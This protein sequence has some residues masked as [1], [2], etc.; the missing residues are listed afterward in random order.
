MA[1]HRLIIIPGYGDRTGYIHRLT[2]SWLRR[3]GVEVE[4]VTFGWRGDSRSYDQKWQ[5]FIAH[6]DRSNPAVVLGISAGASV[7]LRALTEEPQKVLGVVSICGPWTGRYFHADV[8]HTQYPTL[9]S[10]LAPLRPTKFPVNRI[11]TFRPLYDETATTKA[12]SIEGA[13]NV[14][15]PFAFHAVSI[16]LALV[17]YGQT[18]SKFVK[19]PYNVPKAGDS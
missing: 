15:M 1:A 8:M 6:L 18:I 4:V 17:F 2:G 19:T 13:Q 3:Y 16:V 10:S 12:V 11:L 7:A 9:E 14:R 5:A